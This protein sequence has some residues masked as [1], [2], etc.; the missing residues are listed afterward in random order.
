MWGTTSTKD[1]FT[2]KW[3]NGLAM[4]I[5]KVMGSSQE[6]L[7]M[8]IVKKAYSSTTVTLREL[9]AKNILLLILSWRTSPI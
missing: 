6:S 7:R 8:K 5:L 1:S 2:T 4:G 9:S 3:S